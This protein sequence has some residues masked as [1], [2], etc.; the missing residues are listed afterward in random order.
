VFSWIGVELPRYPLISLVF[1]ITLV[2]GVALFVRGWKGLVFV[3]S[4]VL[5][6]VVLSEISKLNL[7]QYIAPKV[8][9]NQMDQNSIDRAAGRQR[10]GQLGDL[11]VALARRPKRTLRVGQ[12]GFSAPPYEVP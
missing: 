12:D 4:L 3:V 7:L 2:A 9:D 11:V 5:A 8:S 6:L 10:V 1:T